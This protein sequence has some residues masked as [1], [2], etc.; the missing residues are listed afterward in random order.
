M[1]LQKLEGRLD[2]RKTAAANS[3]AVGISFKFINLR[4][5]N[6]IMT[7]GTQRM[8]RRIPCA[9]TRRENGCEE[10]R[11]G[12]SSSSQQDGGRHAKEPEEDQSNH[13]GR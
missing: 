4:R 12:S 9:D 13:E 2:A 10:G 1:M 6:A 7:G 8:K 3:M 11:D 5:N